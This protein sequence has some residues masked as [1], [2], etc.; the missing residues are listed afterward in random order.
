MY[1]PHLHCMQVHAIRS[2]RRRGRAALLHAH[3][4]RNARRHTRIANQ[5]RNNSSY[6][7]TRDLTCC[8]CFSLQPAS[9]RPETAASSASSASST[10]RRSLLAPTQPVQLPP[11]LAADKQV[12][13]LFAYAQEGVPDSQ[14][15]QLRV[16]RVE[17]HYH[18]A[19]NTIALHVSGALRFACLPR[20]RTTAAG[21]R[22]LRCTSPLTSTRY[23]H[24][25]DIAMFD[26][27]RSRTRI[28]AACCKALCCGAT[29]FLELRLGVRP[30]PSS[31]SRRM[32]RSTLTGLTSSLETM[33]PSTAG[34]LFV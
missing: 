28:T 21:K 26:Q 7:Y 27:R 22:R 23:A 2:Q 20:K 33:F 29:A 4:L 13:R 30:R 17:I 12:L 8:H 16:R 1:F 32:A 15:E 10:M 3:R 25:R 19:D 5:A 24:F 18:I 9:A 34:T 11:A 14:L 31:L 6:H